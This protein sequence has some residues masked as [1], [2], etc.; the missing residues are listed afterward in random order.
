MRTPG[1][2]SLVVEHPGAGGIESSPAFLVV[3]FK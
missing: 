3:K 1:L 2:Y